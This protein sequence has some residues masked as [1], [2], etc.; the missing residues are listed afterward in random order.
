MLK[1]SLD[2]TTAFFGLIALLPLLLV[3][4][5]L[6][7]FKL[8]LPILFTQIRPGK[9]AKPFRMVKFRSMTDERDA[10][11]HLLPDAIRL[12]GFGRFLR[13][14]SMDELP[15]LWNVVI[16]DLSLVGPRPLAML[17]VFYQRSRSSYLPRIS[18]IT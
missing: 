13:S 5:V 18:R 7:R 9:N 8:G 15:S 1:R 10:S 6:I 4:A 14:T 16:G 12:T 17:C 3:L 2:F 11:G